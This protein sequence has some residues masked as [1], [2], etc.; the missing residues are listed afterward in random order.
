MNI[1]KIPTFAGYI[2]GAQVIFCLD[3]RVQFP[4]NNQET[5]KLKDGHYRGTADH[6]R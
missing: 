1:F 3:E 6:I 4:A 2:F 5:K